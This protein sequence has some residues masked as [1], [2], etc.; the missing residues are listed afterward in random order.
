MFSCISKKYITNLAHAP[1][2]SW[3][4]STLFSASPWRGSSPSAALTS[5][6]RCRCLITI[7]IS[8]YQHK[9]IETLFF[10]RARKIARFTTSSPLFCSH[11]SS[12]FQNGWKLKRES[13]APAMITQ[14]VSEQHLSSKRKSKVILLFRRMKLFRCD[15]ISTFDHVCHS[16][17]ITLSKYNKED[18]YNLHSHF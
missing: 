16:V 14:T 18:L 2:A 5:T 9:C 1:P 6:G 8:T 3:P 11:S 10:D 15:S 4:A 13:G 17:S 7:V 12:T